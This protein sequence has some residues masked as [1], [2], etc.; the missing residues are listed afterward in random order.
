MLERMSNGK[1]WSHTS[2]GSYPIVYLTADGGCVCPSCANCDD[3]HNPFGEGPDFDRDHRLVGADVHWEGFAI[4]CDNC[5][6]DIDSAYG[7][8]DDDIASA[9]ANGEL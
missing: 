7:P 1:L 8:T 2:V 9:E 6:A 5:S 3:K 4:Q